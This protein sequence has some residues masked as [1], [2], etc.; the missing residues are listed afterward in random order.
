M[1]NEELV[2][3]LQVLKG[4]EFWKEGGIL[5]RDGVFIQILN[6]Y[7]ALKNS[8]LL[9]LDKKAL[10]IWGLLNC[11]GEPQVKAKYFFDMI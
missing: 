6:E 4:I 9:L 11:K 5:S 8:Q 2:S 3:S 7:Q 1:K 10:L